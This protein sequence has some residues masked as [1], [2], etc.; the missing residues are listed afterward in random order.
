[1][2]TLFGWVVGVYQKPYSKN[3]AKME[4]GLSMSFFQLYVNEILR[5]F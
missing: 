3:N 1:M 4:F 2:I 5:L